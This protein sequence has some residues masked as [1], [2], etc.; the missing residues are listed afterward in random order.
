MTGLFNDRYYLNL[1]LAVLFTAGIGVSLYLIYSLPANLRLTD[2]YQSDFISIYSILILTFILGAVTLLSALRYKKEIIVMRDR[3]VDTA[4]AEREAAEQAGKTSIS[5]DTVKNNLS[6]ASTEK[7]ILQAGLQAV[8]KQLE[9]GQGAI[10]IVKEEDSKRKVELKNGYALT[11]GESTVISY[12]FGEGLI[13]Q[14]AASARTLYVDD[15]PQGYV[16]IISGLGSASP[17]YLLIVP[18]KKDRVLG[19]VEIASFTGL[20]EDQRK[21]VEESA[22]LIADKISTRA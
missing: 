8:C 4:S 16:K 13:G 3:I 1:I 18:I 21:F 14:A 10:Y 2:G 15:V 9:A 20:T 11:I 19:I 6:Q 12:E 5:L 17:K 22:E 7:E